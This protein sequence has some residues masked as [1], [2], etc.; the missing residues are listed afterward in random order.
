MRDDLAL[1][2]LVA[3][4]IC[5]DLIS[6]VGA[7]SNGMELLAMTGDA[8]GPEAALVA[9]SARSASAGLRFL[10][11]AFGGATDET[12]ARE[13]LAAIAAAHLGGARLAFDWAAPGPPLTRRAARIALLTAM[14]A[15]AALPLGGAL[16]VETATDAPLSAAARFVGERAGF[17]EASRDLIAGTLSPAAADPRQAPLALLRAHAD[18]L[19]APLAVTVG[20][21]GGRLGFG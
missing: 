16:T 9:D 13:E 14:A 1:S 3:S 12:V 21:G 4:R 19:G 7:V 18:A 6:P 20:E 15:A 17:D 2:A 5:H 11:I 8:G 10:R